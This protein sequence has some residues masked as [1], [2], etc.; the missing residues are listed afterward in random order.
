MDR[1]DKTASRFGLEAKEWFGFGFKF[2]WALVNGDT[3][4]GDL[5]EKVTRIF[6]GE[7]SKLA[8]TEAITAA[9]L[10]R[11]M[12]EDAALERKCDGGERYSRSDDDEHPIKSADRITAKLEDERAENAIL[13]KTID[14]R[15]HE[16]TLLRHDCN[17]LLDILHGLHGKKSH[18]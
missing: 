4:G 15:D 11:D 3:S 8:L 14:S 5:G 10:G 6:D 17:R 1:L 2:G 7:T 12:A 18:G 13:R 16:I 9:R